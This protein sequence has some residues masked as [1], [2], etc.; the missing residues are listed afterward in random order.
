MKNQ[1]ILCFC[2][3]ISQQTGILNLI[4]FNSQAKQFKSL[5]IQLIVY[6][7]YLISG[8]YCSIVYPKHAIVDDYCH[9]MNQQCFI[10]IDICSIIGQQ[11]STSILKYFPFKC[12]SSPI[13]L[14][15]N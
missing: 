2:S 6:P 3:A 11:W 7:K 1:A 9:I 10:V 12:L 14:S 5:P 4:G 8:D 15:K 13:F